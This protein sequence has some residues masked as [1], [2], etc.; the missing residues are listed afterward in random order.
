MWELVSSPN[1]FSMMNNNFIWR[2]YPSLFSI[3]KQNFGLSEFWRHRPSSSWK[4]GNLSSSTV[5]KFGKLE[6]NHFNVLWESKTSSSGRLAP[7]DG[8]Q[9]S[10][11]SIA[12]NN[13]ERW[14]RIID[15]TKNNR[16]V[17]SRWTPTPLFWTRESWASTGFLNRRDHPKIIY[18]SIKY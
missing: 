6:R 18:F 11:K 16:V 15:K 12:V 2:Q 8:W 17:R 14:F 7:F 3:S 5:S 9:T 1:Y 10:S 13:E 4:H